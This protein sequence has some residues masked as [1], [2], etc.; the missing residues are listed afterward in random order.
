M[1]LV[2]VYNNPIIKYSSLKKIVTSKS[3][4]PTTPSIAFLVTLDSQ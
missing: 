2:L 4:K 1:L 3:P